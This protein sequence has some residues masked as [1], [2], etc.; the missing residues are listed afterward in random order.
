MGHSWICWAVR[1]VVSTV[2]LTVS[3]NG[4]EMKVQYQY[5]SISLGRAARI[6]LL[7][8]SK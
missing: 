2:L 6:L 5:R 7:Y 1:G 3:G 8:C 4:V